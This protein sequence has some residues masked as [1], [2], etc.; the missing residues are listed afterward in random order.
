MSLTRMHGVI[1]RLRQAAAVAQPSDG[2]L[3][4]A[5]LKQRD[6]AAF[7]KLLRRHAAMVLGV[8]RRVAGPNEADDAFQATFLVLVR[9]AAS[10]V[11]REA[12]GNW[13]YG[14]AYR[15]A[16]RARAEAVRRRAKEKQVNDMPH[17]ALT[18]ATT[19]AELEQVLDRELNRLPDKYRLPIVLCDLEGRTRRA[20]ARQLG[21]P[22]GT[23]SN[24][25]AAGRQL[26]ANRL[27]K[28][29]FPASG[30][31]VGAWLMEQTATASVPAALVSATLGV[32]ATGAGTAKV[33]ALAGGVVKGMLLAK[34]KK[35]TAGLILCVL[36]GV[37]GT[38]Y[39]VSA[40]EQ[41]KPDNAAA[42]AGT[43]AAAQ[44]PP[45]A[46]AKRR[47][48]VQRRAVAAGEQAAEKVRE[49]GEAFERDMTFFDHDKKTNYLDLDTG[50]F[51]EP[52]I[53]DRP[54][55]DLAGDLGLSDTRTRNALN[56]SVVPIAH[57]AHPMPS[58][59]EITALLAKSAAKP[60]Q[61]IGGRAESYLFKTATGTIGFLNM[62]PINEAQGIVRVRWRPLRREA[63]PPG[64]KTPSVKTP[65]VALNLDKLLL[66]SW[67]GRGG[68]IP[69]ALTLNRDNTFLLGIP[70]NFAAQTGDWE[71]STAELPFVL[72]LHIKKAEAR[73]R[74]GVKLR[75]EVRT[76]SDTTLIVEDRANWRSIGYQRPTEKG[77]VP[78]DSAFPP[79]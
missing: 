65:A 28:L 7:E 40:L 24:R 77:L 39:R 73:D 15:I 35:A 38:A 50:E 58:A 36:L 21:I 56:M 25:I 68:L 76:L 8:C 13:L 52:G 62:E 12:V 2:Q 22:D 30:G 42:Q 31:A 3:L 6:H 1:G 37:G 16:L 10:I 64:G 32:A 41:Q 47:A 55:V 44:S 79:K 75:W 20:V 4:D 59:A 27:T 33:A 72:T 57:N 17:P 53:K 23:L 51:V 18:G 67:I 45:E 78:D 66:G 60:S 46:E 43:P 34:L 29:G 5:F 63:L 14:V 49:W 70:G 9:K 11:P 54:K 48:E 69:S 61:I 74:V 26:L 19:W 71:L